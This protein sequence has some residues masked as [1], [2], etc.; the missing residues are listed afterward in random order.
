[1]KILLTGATGFLGSHLAKALVKNNH[2]VAITKRSFSDP[3]R[4]AAITSHVTSYDLDAGQ[5]SRAFEDFGGFDYIIH[6]ATQYD[7]N[8]ESYLSLVESNLLFPLKLLELV[9]AYPQCTFINTDSFISKGNMHYRYLIGY[10]LTK[11]QFVEWGKQYSARGK[12]RFINVKLEHIYGPLDHDNK[13]IPSMIRSCLNNIPELRLTPGQQIRDFIYIDDV[14]QA[15]EAVMRS[16]SYDSSCYREFELGTGQ[17]IKIRQAVEMI[18][19]LTGS[20]SILT[21]GALTYRDGEIMES[22]ANNLEL[23]KLGWSN[24]TTLEDGLSKTISTFRHM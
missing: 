23:R 4:I 2:Q 21:F 10:A 1:M 14:V 8:G 19:R 9:S 11:R 7:R 6:T 3:W 24:Q 13:F 18:H 15:Y 22:T 17:P 5:L 20:Q 16:A 12:I